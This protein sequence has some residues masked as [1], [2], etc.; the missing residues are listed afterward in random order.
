MKRVLIDYKKLNHKTVE[1]LIEAYPYG[2]GDEDIITLQKSNGDI[3]EAVEVKT[4]DA[5]YMVKIG[6]NFSRFMSHSEENLEKE[7]SKA[8]PENV[9]TPNEKSEYDNLKFEPDTDLESESLH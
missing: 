2:Y 5:V 6:K 9:I 7:L 3:I 8:L 4:E 1:A